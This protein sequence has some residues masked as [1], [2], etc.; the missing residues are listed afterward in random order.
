MTTQTAPSQTTDL[1]GDYVLDVA[2]T[3]L[4][5]VA[6]HAMITKVR[7]AFNDFEGT[8]VLDG[9]NP[10]NSSATV[11]IQVKS[12]D[13]RQAQRDEV[14]DGFFLGLHGATRYTSAIAAGKRAG[15]P[16]A[17]IRGEGFAITR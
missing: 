15:Y 1:T 10:A 4:G 8:A 12:I 7:G 3:R 11:A 9:D 5:F 2:H 16:P 6:R 13:T 14:A 17:V